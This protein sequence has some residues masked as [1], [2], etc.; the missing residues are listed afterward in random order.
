MDETEAQIG[1]VLAL[2]RELQSPDARRSE[3]RL[4]ELLAPGFIEIGAS[5]RRWDLETILG[6]LAAESGDGDGGA[7]AIGIRDLEARVLAPGIIQVLWDSDRDGCRA[8]RT[9]LWQ[10]TANG[11]RQTYHQGTPLP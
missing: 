1:D 8:R 7:C 3:R 5:G 9:S 6:L 4:R 11:W 10:R 2:E